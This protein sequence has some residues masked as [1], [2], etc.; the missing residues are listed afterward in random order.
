MMME[1]SNERRAPITPQLALRVALLGG[2]AFAL[3]AII[4]F[5]LWYL[6]VLSGDQFLA[7][8]TVNRVRE[9]RI[10]AP[11]GNIVDRS[12]HVLVENRLAVVV[13]LDPATLPQAERSLA[14]KWGYDVNTRLAKPKGHRGEPVSIPPIPTAD[15]KTRYRRLGRVLGLSTSEVHHIVVRSLVIVPYTSVR[16]KTDVSDS[17]LAYI[18]ERP[19]QF[20]GIKVDR[21]YL[22]TYPRGSLAAQVLGNVSE[23][24]PKEQ[25]LPEFRGVA[26]GTV[27]GQDGV[28]RT[29][30]RYL[31]GVDGIQRVQVNASGQPVHNARLRRDE[32]V[33]G[34]RLRL[35]LDLNL[36]EA[37]QQA[38]AALSGGKPGAFIAMDPRDGSLLALGSYP[39]YDP[40][41]FTKELTQ[42]RYDELLGDN[43]GAPLVDRAIAGQYPTGSVFKAVTALAGLQKGLITPSTT[44]DDAG[45]IQVGEI[46]RCNAKHQAYGPVDL[47]KA[48]QVSS[49]VY[50]YQL[51]KEAFYAHGDDFVIQR[52]ARKLGFGRLSG[53]DLPGED[54]GVIPDQ[55]WRDR[56]N[57]RE[58]ACRKKLGIPISADVFT[59]GARGCG[60]SDL[61]DYNLGDTVNL[62]VGQ[63]DLQ[64]TPLQLAVAYAA[65]ENKGHIVVP[66]L[67]ME[68]DSPSG[69]LVQRIQRDPARKVSIDE[70]DREVVAEG[71]HLSTSAP[72][73]TSA[74]VFADWPQDQFPV[75]GKT[76]TAQRPPK[77]DQSWYVA[78]VPD[79]KRP[80]VV[81]A[82]VEEGGFG[83]ARAAP[84]ACRILAKYYNQHVACTPGKDASQ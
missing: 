25:K 55:N 77:D 56:V 58:R 39:S 81:V 31:R 71:L 3:F 63:G 34:Q 50:F 45:C 69:E 20:P 26:P 36:E 37:G 16:L 65:I 74:D 10:Q 70:A 14:A 78:Y 52:Y 7:Q 32:P 17:V 42:K 61:R 60:I 49:D 27:V 79:A 30:D 73:G 19:E 8:A 11:R 1:P 82:T 18:S 51:G 5:R 75:Y 59:A 76:G 46:K 41:L 66:H 48:I 68:I 84:I 15:L 22:R 4:F 21:T 9:I 72:G 12:G 40:T 29:Y 13:E 28:E 24:N 67:G 53:V 54:N 23:I 64:A 80:I 83:A 38:F 35:S 57:A 44:V 62:A 33:A 6:Q 43:A 2:V 47:I